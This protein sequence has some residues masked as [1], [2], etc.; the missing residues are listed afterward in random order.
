MTAIAILKDEKAQTV[1]VQ[2]GT[3][4]TQNEI[5]RWKLAD[6]IGVRGLNDAVQLWDFI[7]HS[8]EK[9]TLEVSLIIILRRRTNLIFSILS[10][11]KCFMGR[12][13]RCEQRGQWKKIYNYMGVCYSYVLGTKSISIINQS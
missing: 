13:I 2:N 6:L 5:D 9:M 8:M 11:R 7:A 1:A 4:V 10:T 3:V 12:N